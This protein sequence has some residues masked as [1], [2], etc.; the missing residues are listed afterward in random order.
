VQ[1][2]A[3]V[4]YLGAQDGNDFGGGGDSRPD[5]IGVA[6]MLIGGGAL[7]AGIIRAA[8]PPAA[9]TSNARVAIAPTVI[10]VGDRPRV[11]L[12]V[13]ARF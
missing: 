7:A 9:K 5:G 13:N 1:L 4:L 8:K 12:T 2:I 6:N 10:P 11:G 3:G